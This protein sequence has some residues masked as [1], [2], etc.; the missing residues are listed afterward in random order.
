M[1]VQVKRAY[2][3]VADADGTRVLVDRLWPR[4][5]SKELAHIDLWLKDL[6]PT[7]ALRRAW[8]ST[9]GWHDGE[10]FDTFR[11]SYA[12]ELTGADATPEASRALEELRTL[13]ADEPRVT[14]ITA[15]KDPAIS[16]VV[17]LLELLGVSA[18]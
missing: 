11:A 18:E 3:D 1:T 9:S 8:H 12:D 14:L 6:T 15:S 10:G 4:G 5:L 2:D 17:V 7:T 16:H 13:I